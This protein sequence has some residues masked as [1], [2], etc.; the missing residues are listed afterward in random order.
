M[1]N[2]YLVRL[3]SATI[4]SFDG[5]KSCTYCC[6]RPSA[7]QS[8][9]LP[10]LVFCRNFRS[11]PGRIRTCDRRIRSPKHTILVRTDASES[12]PNLQG[13]SEFSVERLSVAYWLVP[14]RLQYGCSK[15]IRANLDGLSVS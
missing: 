1:R 2:T 10:F 6:H 11:A 12:S 13:F 7:R 4:F 14:A 8:A 5:G 15:F 9:A 3:R